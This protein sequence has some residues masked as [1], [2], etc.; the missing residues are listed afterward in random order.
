MPEQQHYDYV[1]EV[2]T[3]SCMLCEFVPQKVQTRMH[4]STLGVH[5]ALHLGADASEQ[6]RARASSG[7]FLRALLGVEMGLAWPRANVA[8]SI[9]LIC[10]QHTSTPDRRCIR[11]KL[12]RSCTQK[13][14]VAVH[15]HQ[16]HDCGGTPQ[17]VQQ[18]APA[19]NAPINANQHPAHSVSAQTDQ[20]D[21]R[22]EPVPST[23][24]IMH[25]M[26]CM[27]APFG[28]VSSTESKTDN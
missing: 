18:A 8:A 15:W 7:C 3:I 13:A 24:A 26:P 17:C 21:V 23:P 1:D 10:A 20:V 5:P 27:T 16:Q 14:V 12:C 9:A 11:A 22:S 4:E 19:L 25:P 28:S 2:S 6:P